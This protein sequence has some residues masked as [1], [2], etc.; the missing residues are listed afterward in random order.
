[1][2]KIERVARALCKFAVLNFEGDPSVDEDPVATALVV[3]EDW[4]DFVEEAK[5]AIA[6]VEAV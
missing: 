5:V 6:A 1:M 4:P 2:E 3:E